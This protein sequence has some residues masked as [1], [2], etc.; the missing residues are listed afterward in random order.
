MPINYWMMFLTAILRCSECG[1]AKPMTM[2]LSLTVLSSSSG[3]SSA[4]V[5]TNLSS[6]TARISSIEGVSLASYAMTV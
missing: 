2:L 5:L 6:C 3:I 1:S 4:R